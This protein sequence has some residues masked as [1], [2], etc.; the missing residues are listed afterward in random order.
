MTS[1]QTLATECDVR[2]I[3]ASFQRDLNS[4][5]MKSNAGRTPHH[6]L[7]AASPRLHEPDVEFELEACLNAVADV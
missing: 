2:M 6:P 7:S 3:Q 4:W 1:T 5:L